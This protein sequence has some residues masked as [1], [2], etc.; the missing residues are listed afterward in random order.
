MIW[1]HPPPPPCNSGFVFLFKFMEGANTNLHKLLDG[2]QGGRVYPMH[3]HSFLLFSHEKR[4]MTHHTS[5]ASLETSCLGGDIPPFIPPFAFL[6]HPVLI[7]LDWTTPKRQS[8]PNT[9]SWL[10]AFVSPP[11]PPPKKKR[12]NDIG[13]FRQYKPPPRRW[14]FMERWALPQRNHVLN[15]TNPGIPTGCRNNQ[16]K[17]PKKKTPK[18][19]PPLGC[20]RKLVNG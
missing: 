16:Q 19:Y 11:S 7:A 18:N 1:V 20:P 17:Q 6:F 2:I 13:P 8:K 15:T 10:A 14:N 5:L 12:N 4:L 3:D 9:T